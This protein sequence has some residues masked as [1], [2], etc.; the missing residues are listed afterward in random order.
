MGTDKRARQKANRQSRL[1]EVQAETTKQSRERSFK[2]IVKFGAVGVAI[3]AVFLLISALRGGDDSDS[4]I[5]FSP[6]TVPGDDNDVEVEQ[7]AAPAELLA[8]IPADFEPFSATGVL[9][10]TVPTIRNNVYDSAPPMTIDPARSYAAVL[11]TDAGVI[12]LQLFADEAPLAVNNFVNLARDGF[13]DGVV[14]HRVLEDFM[15]QSGD[16]TG[17]G[18]GGPGYSFADEFTSGREF[19][20]RGLLAMANSGP[21]SNGSQ[22]FITFTEQPSLNNVHTIFGEVVGDDS[23]LDN[24]LRVNPGQGQVTTIQ[25]VSIVEG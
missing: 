23:V 24:I 16:P 4:G 9:A 2:R 14:F 13:Y 11:T 22:F 10:A 25:S 18:T 21:D 7:A 20:K 6:A 19:D 1:A 17:S 8:E 3:V 15:A 12:R 5:D